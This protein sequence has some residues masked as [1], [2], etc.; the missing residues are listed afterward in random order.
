MHRSTYDVPSFIGV[1]NIYMNAED[2]ADQF[3]RVTVTARGGTKGFSTSF[4]VKVDF[5]GFR[6][7]PK[8]FRKLCLIRNWTLQ[9]VETDS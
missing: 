3:C 9:S 4:G 5:L 1:Y 7:F 6:S 8:V 2:L